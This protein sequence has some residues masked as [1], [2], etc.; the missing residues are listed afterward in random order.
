MV[1]RIQREFCLGAD[2]SHIAWDYSIASRILLVEME[3]KPYC[4]RIVHLY[5]LCVYI[6]HFGTKS[7][8]PEDGVVIPRI[9][10]HKLDAS[11]SNLGA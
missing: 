5:L 10:S 9:S 6:L 2:L 4:Y 8:Y 1:D 11:L 7:C 3:W